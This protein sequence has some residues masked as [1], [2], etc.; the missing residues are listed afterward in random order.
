MIRCEHDQ[1]ILRRL[2]EEILEKQSEIELKFQ[3]KVEKIRNFKTMYFVSPPKATKL[4]MIKK[5]M[6]CEI[7]SESNSCPGNS[8]TN[9][10]EL[11]H[12]SLSPK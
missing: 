6:K 4:F 9:N 7:E 8:K 12:N 3:I 1:G 10:L 2:E 5:V 11:Q